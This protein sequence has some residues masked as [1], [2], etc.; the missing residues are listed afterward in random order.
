MIYRLNTVVEF[1][2]YKGQTLD[3]I[4]QKNAS[5]IVWCIKNLEHFAVETNVISLLKEMS[6]ITDD[7]AMENQEKI[8]DYL[9]SIQERSHKPAYD[10]YERE[11]YEEF[12][13]TYAQDVA[14]YSDEDIWDIFDGEPDAYWNID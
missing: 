9:E 12:A 4:M 11:H 13:G 8:D 6:V 3:S 1:G 7:I 5:Y 14:G 2:K 10:Y